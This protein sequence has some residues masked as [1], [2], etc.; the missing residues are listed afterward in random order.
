MSQLH[1]W[2]NERYGLYIAVRNSRNVYFHL[3]QDEMV[4][5]VPNYTQQY[6]IEHPELNSPAPDQLNPPREDC[7]PEEAQACAKR[8]P[9]DEG[10]VHVPAHT[11]ARAT[12]YSAQS[13]NGASTHP[14]HPPRQEN[15]SDNT[16]PLTSH[17][18]QQ[19]HQIKKLE[20]CI[21]G[22]MRGNWR[23]VRTVF[24][25][26]GLTPLKPSRPPNPDCHSER[27]EESAVVSNGK[28]LSLNKHARDR[29]KS[30]SMCRQNIA[31]N[32]TNPSTRPRR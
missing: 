4:R 5:Q 13:G 11:D 32:K 30:L 16:P 2:V 23:D 17:E 7:H 9:A 31:E 21:E 28:K 14:P 1:S 20:A 8:R 22:A 18:S 25:A 6:L 19:W 12:P 26:V 3:R 29:P 27:S 24:N 10:S 15:Q